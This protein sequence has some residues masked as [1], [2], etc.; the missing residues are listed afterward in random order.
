MAKKMYVGVSDVARKV[1]KMYVGVNGVARKVKKAYV[2]VNGVAQQ[3]Y[4]ALPKIVTWNGGTDAE[5]VAMVAA[6]DRG[7]IN[8]SDYWS[9]GDKRTVS[10]PYMSA[11]DVSETHSAQ[12][13]TYVLLNVGGKELYGGGTCSF[14][15]GLEDS[16]YER[17]QISSSTYNTNGWRGCARRT[18]CNNKYKNSIPS[19]LSPIFKQ[20]WNTTS[21]GG[22]RS[23]LESVA[24]WHAL[25]AE[26]E[27]QGTVTFSVAGEGTQFTW[28]QTAANR[29]KYSN[30]SQYWYFTRSPFA[31]Q[32]VRWCSENGTAIAHSDTTEYLGISPIGVI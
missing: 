26:I 3:F 6:A 13:V 30:G 24:D 31:S 5:I 16:L 14:V 15:V 8:L 21:I 2:G 28:Y 23:T 11:V 17:G 32:E 1:S 22:G 9:V 27:I 20:F 19:T 12:N 7:E 10:L 29:S 18:W 25:A 4:T